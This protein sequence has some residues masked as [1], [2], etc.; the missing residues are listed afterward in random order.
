MEAAALAAGETRYKARIAREVEV[1]VRQVSRL[2][3]GKLDRDLRR[4]E[5]RGRKKSSAKPMVRVV[6]RF[7]SLTRSV[8][9]NV[10]LEQPAVCNMAGALATTT[11]RERAEPAEPVSIRSFPPEIL[12]S[13][14]L[15]FPNRVVFSTTRGREQKKEAFAR[16]AESKV[17]QAGGPQ[18]QASP[19][20]D[21]HIDEQT[22]ADS[23]AGV[24]PAG[25]TSTNAVW[26]GWG[27][28]AAIAQAR[29]GISGKRQANQKVI[30]S[31]GWVKITRPDGRTKSI[32][33]I[34]IAAIMKA[35]KAQAPKSPKKLS[36]PT[37]IYMDAKTGEID[38]TKLRAEVLRIQ[39][40]RARAT[41]A[42]R[43]RDVA[44]DEAARA[45]VALAAS[46]RLKEIIDRSK[47]RATV[48]DKD[49]AAQKSLDQN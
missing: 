38:F 36:G 30:P 28:L 23:V 9:F 25:E 10:G 27:P 19:K 35:A 22:P 46:N 26:T 43:I 42:A 21:A 20:V 45:R 4:V 47:R 17:F 24:K 18:A 39:E 29:S 7:G 13:L 15:A 44:I 34:P 32:P 41:E 33:L 1:D 48:E 2:L 11:E 3:D 14:A 16:K 49:N 12:C 5:T 37:P 8:W 31:E 40:E 6:E